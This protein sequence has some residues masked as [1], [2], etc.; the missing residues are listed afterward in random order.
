MDNTKNDSE[1][2]QDCGG[3]LCL[4]CGDGLVCL[5]PSDCKSSVCKPSDP[6]MPA[7]CQP[8]TCT[9]G[10]QNGDEEGRDCGGMTSMCPPCAK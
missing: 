1:T 9:D 3:A 7:R 2:D 5:V 10:V 8:P 6:G 4:P